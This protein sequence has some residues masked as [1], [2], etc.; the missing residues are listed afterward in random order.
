MAIIALQGMR[1]GVGT[2]SITAALA[3][4]LQQLGESVLVIDATP[5]NLLRMH[6]NTDFAH[7]NGWARAELMVRLGKM[8]RYV[9]PTCLIFYLS[10]RLAQMSM[11]NSLR[12]YTAGRTGRKTFQHC[13]PMAVITGFC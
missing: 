8:R 10:D 13:V 12:T 5:A 6:F 7:T 9:T 1:G 4:G 11:R 2:T 3:W